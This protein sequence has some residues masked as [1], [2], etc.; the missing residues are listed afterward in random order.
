MRLHGLEWHFAWA[1]ARLIPVFDPKGY[2][3]C[4]SQGCY[5][6]GHWPPRE[7]GICPRPWPYWKPPEGHGCQPTKTMG[8]LLGID[9]STAWRI[10]V[11]A[12][13]LGLVPCMRHPL[14]EPSR[15]PQTMKIQQP[16]LGSPKNL[17]D[18][19]KDRSLD[20]CDR[21]SLPQ[22][23]SQKSEVLSF[24]NQNVPFT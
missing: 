20:L 5:P 23:A 9:G 10:P 19:L 8:S 4:R 15:P 17:P 3:S 11:G 13:D 21:N 24:Q 14:G 18:E 2:Q 16:D 12:F 6:H 1:T 22:C 7:S